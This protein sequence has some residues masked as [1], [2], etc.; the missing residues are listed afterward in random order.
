MNLKTK[1]MKNF[2]LLLV[3][4]ASASLSQAKT[5]TGKVTDYDGGLFGVVV[6]VKGAKTNT[7]TDFDGNYIIETQTTDKL[8]LHTLDIM[9]KKF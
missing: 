3:F 9:L 7:T 1:I 2:L 6:S 8:V 4:I 5:I